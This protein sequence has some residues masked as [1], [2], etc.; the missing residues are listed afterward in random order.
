MTAPDH[1]PTEG[2]E[3]LAALIHGL[4]GAWQD[5]GYE[6]PPT[7]DCAVIPPLGE[8]SADAIR[9]GHE[10]ITDIDRL[11]AQLYG[12]RSTLVS[13][14]RRDADIRMARP[15]PGAPAVSAV[16]A[17]LDGEPVPLPAPC[18]EYVTGVP[19]GPCTTCGRTREAHRLQGD[20]RNPENTTEGGTS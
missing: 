6:D 17:M 12:V 10:A 19:Y 2:L 8:R 18:G 9:A 14:L 7:P 11:L 15:L 16:V 5:F 3:E 4:V 1:V 20:G 13:Q